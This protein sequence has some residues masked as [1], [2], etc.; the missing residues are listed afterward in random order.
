M[1]NNAIARKKF[2]KLGN[3]DKNKF[4]RYEWFGISNSS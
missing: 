1:D 2:L 3:H 4:N